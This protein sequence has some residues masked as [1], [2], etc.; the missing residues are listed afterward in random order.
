MEVPRGAIADFFRYFCETPVMV[1]E[2][3]IKRYR[4]IWEFFP[5][6]GPPT[7]PFGNLEHFLPYLFGQ[8][9]NFWVILRCFKGVFRAMV[10]ITKVLGIGKTPPP[11]PPMLGQIPKKSHIFFEGVPL[12]YLVDIQ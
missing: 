12:R 6:V 9:G 8:V 4:I 3:L 1:R 7:P 11:P 2:T 10:E 5:N